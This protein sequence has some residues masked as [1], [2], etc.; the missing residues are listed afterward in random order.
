MVAI[1]GPGIAGL[2]AATAAVKAQHISKTPKA[3]TGA[4]PSYSLAAGDFFTWMLPLEPQSAYENW[5]SNVEDEMW[6][7]LYWAGKGSK[8][9]IDYTRSIGKPPVYS[10]NDRTVTIAMKTGF[11]WSTGATVTS[12]DVKFF[13]QLLDA[14][15]KKLG[16]YLPGLMPTNVASITYPSSTTFVLHLKRSYNP[17]WF[18]G[19]QLMWIYPLPV[20]AWDRSSPTSPAGSAASTPA[21]ATKVFT[22]LFSQSKQRGTY[23]S[24]PLWKTVDGPFVISAYNTATHE[25]QFVTNSH[26]TGPTKPRIAGYKVYTFTTNTAELDALRSGTLTFGYIPFGDLKEI[27]YFKSHGFT[28]K[29]WPVFYEQGI[30]FGYT[31]KTWGPLVNQLYIRQALQHLITEKLYINRTMGGYGLQDYGPIANYPG[32]AYVSPGI[33]KDPYPFSPSLAASMLKAHGWAK[34]TGGV[35][36]CAHPGTGSSNCGRGIPKGKKLSFSMVYSTG[37]TS[38]FA[39]VSAFRTAAARAGVGIALKGQT[40]TTMYSTMGVCPSTP[41]CN[42]G[43]AAYSGFMW[44]YGQYELVPSGTQ[45]WAKGN[46][47]GGGYNSPTAQKLIATA[48][49]KP[50]LRALYAAENY[51]SKNVASL[52]WPLEDYE[53]A[54]VKNTLSGWQHLNP[55]ATFVPQ[56]WHVRKS[57]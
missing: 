10:N 15:K 56:A 18:T 30:E 5:N 52:W 40:L 51:L 41:P 25:A 43:L 29:A 31:S 33:K 16:N 20:Q 38:F 11:K 57:G 19:N 14:G 23:A 34:G 55:Y 36:V 22:M 9:G 8:T 54:A 45:Q 17:T 7:P 12:N 13:F 6:L 47:W 42:W 35:D 4:M 3:H 50:S 49:T 1:L 26:Y 53:V 32:S 48:D 21:G 28:I 27:S 37:T 39:E 46:Y 2:P 24:N 44:D